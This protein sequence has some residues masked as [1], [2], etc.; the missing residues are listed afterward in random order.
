MLLAVI[1]L[2]SACNMKDRELAEKI[3]GNAN[4]KKVKQAIDA[5]ASGVLVQRGR[6]DEIKSAML[7]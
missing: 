1:S 5:G 3:D 4:F 2:F 7:W 6:A